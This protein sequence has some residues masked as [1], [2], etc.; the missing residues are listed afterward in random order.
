MSE[1][2][3]GGDRQWQETLQL[4]LAQV[5]T[6]ADGEML[7]SPCLSVCTMEAASGLCHGCLRTL[8]EIAAWA[9]MSEG[10]KRI[11]WSRIEQRMKALQA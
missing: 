11:V 6:L 4:R 2:A 8:D 10:G 9:A 5:K 7:P 3:S 1:R